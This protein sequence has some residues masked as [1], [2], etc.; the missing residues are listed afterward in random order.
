[1][2]AIP[3]TPALANNTVATAIYG[4]DIPGVA[5]LASPIVDGKF[6]KEQP[7]AV[8]SQVPVIVGSSKCSHTICTRCT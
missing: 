3:N 6:I 7:I 4:I 8:G 5:D 2:D 1:M